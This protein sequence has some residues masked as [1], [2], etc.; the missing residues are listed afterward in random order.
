MRTNA[1]YSTREAAAAKVSWAGL[2]SGPLRLEVK[3]GS[4]RLSVASEVTVASAAPVPSAL[5]SVR[6]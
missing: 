6:P 3:L 5:N 4:T 1:P 2:N